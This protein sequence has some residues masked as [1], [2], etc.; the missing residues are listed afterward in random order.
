[1]GNG[2]T[3]KEHNKGNEGGRGRDEKSHERG[4]SRGKSLN[5]LVV[6][7]VVEWVEEQEREQQQLELVHAPLLVMASLA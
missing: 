3:L 1:V 6:V 5:C 7:V 2:L 4:Q